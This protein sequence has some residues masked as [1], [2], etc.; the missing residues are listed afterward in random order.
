MYPKD[1]RVRALKLMLRPIVRFWIQNTD[2]I[3]EFVDI[4]KAVFVQIAEEE[5]LRAEIASNVSRL[6]AMT[7]V[8][9]QDVKTILKDKEPPPQKGDFLSRVLS[10]W[11]A[12][13]EFQTKAKR[14]RVITCDGADSEFWKLVN[15]VG[16]SVAPATVLFELERSGAVE[17][18]KKGL[19]MVRPTLRHSADLER[20]VKILS[21]DIQFLISAVQE[22]VGTAEVSPNVHM[23]TKADNIFV[24][25]VPKVRK[26]LRAKSKALHREARLFLSECDKDVVEPGAERGEEDPAGVLVAFGT[27]SYIDG[28][29]ELAA[30]S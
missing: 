13:P 27:F 1:Q 18:S 30:S 6:S 16:T 5:L 15:K 26:W 29:E 14:P 23:R 28:D 25:D 4:L 8:H 17:R 9:R 12:D 21:E 24:R 19:K 3:K 22:N 10:R 20:S 11:E 2:T 7:G